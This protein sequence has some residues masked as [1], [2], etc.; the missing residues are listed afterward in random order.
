VRLADPVRDRGETLIE[1]LVAVVIMGTA[2]V[3]IVG[4]LGT[5]IMLSDIHRKQ[6]T[7]A[8]DLSAF[9]AAIQGAVAT[10]P[11]Y[12][13]CA[14]GS[15]GARPYPSYTPGSGYQADIPQVRYWDATTSTFINSCTVSSD[16]GVQLV[17]LH[18]RSDDGR[19]DRTMDIVI[20]KPCRPVDP[21]CT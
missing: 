13:A 4:G 18:V 17:T 19:V 14:T 10:S 7:I 15:T 8:E 5:A 3:A 9:A 12:I 16:P 21:A 1:L 20:R 6:T 2:V 11:G